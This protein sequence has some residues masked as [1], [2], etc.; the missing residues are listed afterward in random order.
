MT[1][2]GISGLA[3]PLGAHDAM[4]KNCFDWPCVAVPYRCSVSLFP[5]RRSRAAT[6]LGAR[7]RAHVAAEMA[8]TYRQGAG[9]LQKVTGNDKAMTKRSGK[10]S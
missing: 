6:P 8:C 3:F 7:N 5:C 10:F 1:P 9:R 4:E 2:T